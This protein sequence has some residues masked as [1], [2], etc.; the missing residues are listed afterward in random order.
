MEILHDKKHSIFFVHNLPLCIL[1][2]C[3]PCLIK[4]PRNI[5][6]ATDMVPR[7]LALMLFLLLA[8][9]LLEIQR[10]A[11]KPKQQLSL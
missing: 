9:D 2:T 1:D 3:S 7:Y 4:T 8:Y 10:E 6:G 11:G 5:V